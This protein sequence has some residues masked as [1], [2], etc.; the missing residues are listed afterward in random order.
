M[1]NNSWKQLCREIMTEQDP[2]RLFA[3]ADALNKALE[4][5]GAYQEEPVE[6]SLELSV[7]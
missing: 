6:T 3:L 7:C 1:Y 2:E 4:N 5:P